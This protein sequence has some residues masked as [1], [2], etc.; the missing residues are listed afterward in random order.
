MICNPSGGQQS[1]ARLPSAIVRSKQLG[2]FNP[3]DVDDD[4]LD[5]EAYD[6]ADARFDIDITQPGLHKEEKYTP[7]PLTKEDIKFIRSIP[8][9]TPGKASLAMNGHWAFCRE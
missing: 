5:D 6:D 4:L 2:G 9:P 8:N 1:N 3:L 7:Q